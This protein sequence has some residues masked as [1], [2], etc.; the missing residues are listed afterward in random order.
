MI[1]CLHV[2]L[3]IFTRLLFLLIALK[4]IFA[5]LNIRDKGQIY[6]CQQE[7]VILPICE[8]FIFT[9]LPIC[10]CEVSRK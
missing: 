9:K 2:N 7:T 8:D 4:H 6:L 10:I 3:E 5:M 1:P